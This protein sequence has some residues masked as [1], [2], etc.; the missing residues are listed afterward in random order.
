MADAVSIDCAIIGAR[1]DVVEHEFVGALTAIAA[2][3]LGDVAD[4][5]VVAKLNALDHFAVTDIQ[6]GNYASCRNARISCSV[7][8]PSRSARPVMAPSAPMLRRPF[9]SPM[10]R[11]PPAACSCMV[12]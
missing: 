6:A 4:H 7:I 12:G 3:E 5:A 9:R 1:R 11:T 2:R 8:C 10:C